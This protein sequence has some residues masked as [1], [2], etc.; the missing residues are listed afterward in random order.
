MKRGL[1]FWIMAIVF[2]ILIY[3]FTSCPWIGRRVEPTPTPSIP[4]RTLRETGNFP[5]QER[6]RLATRLFRYYQNV[7]NLIAVRE[8]VIFVDS[9]GLK[10]ANASNGDLQWT[11][12]PYGWIDSIAADEDQI[13][14]VGDLGQFIAIEA[15]NLQTGDLA[16]QSNI[17]LPDHTGYYL[18]LHGKRLY[19][20]ESFDLIYIFDTETGNL[21]DKFRVASIGQKPF[22]LL[23]LEDGA[24]LQSDNEQIMLVREGEIVWETTLDGRPQKFPEIYG[25]ILLV[26]VDNDKKV[27][28]GLAGLNLETGDLVWSRPDEFFSN[29]VIVDDLL[30]VISG[31]A[32]ILILD[33][34]NGQTVGSAELLPGSV[35][36]AQSTSAIA[37]NEN[38]LYAY[39]LDSQELIAFEKVKGE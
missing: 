8:G 17:R 36:T 27:F 33:P 11:V 1:S 25:D 5:W 24:W 26:L 28:D 31:K 35:Y 2:G 18:R 23:Q 7:R 30:Y 21:V 6:W 9:L 12:A 15:Y 4:S 34:Q 19:A 39:F 38:M 37:V 29:F 14:I 13:Y 10:F 16:W 32:E 3:S 20:Y 22:S